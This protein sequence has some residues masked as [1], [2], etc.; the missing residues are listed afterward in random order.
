MA[1]PPAFFTASPFSILDKSPLADSPTYLAPLPKT[2]TA[3]IFLSVVVAA[4]VRIHGAPF[5]KVP[6]TGTGIPPREIER[7]STPSSMAA[8][9]PAKI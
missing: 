1:A 9:R 2:A 7:T 3:L 8:S 5:F 6:T 4:T